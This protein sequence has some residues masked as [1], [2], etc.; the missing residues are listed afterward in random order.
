LGGGVGSLGDGNG[1][2]I[3]LSEMK[4]LGSSRITS[5]VQRTDFLFLSFGGAFSTASIAMGSDDLKVVP[6]I[7][8]GEVE[9]VPAVFSGECHITPSIA[10]GEFEITPVIA[11][12]M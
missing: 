10:S 1:L 11:S 8:S 4:R 5:S 2:L 7:A 12:A 9:V 6:A 3:R